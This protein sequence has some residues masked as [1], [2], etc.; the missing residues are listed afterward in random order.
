M[1]PTDPKNFL[2][3][4]S[5]SRSLIDPKIYIKNWFWVQ[6]SDVSMDKAQA[7]VDFF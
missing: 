1:A 2:D 5:R 7:I 4:F 3:L 6:F